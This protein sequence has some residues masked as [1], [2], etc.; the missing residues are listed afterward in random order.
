M[1]CG[2]VGESEAGT[3]RGDNPETSQCSI[4]VQTD[5]KGKEMRKAECEREGIRDALTRLPNQS[6]EPH[7]TVNVT[8]YSI[9]AYAFVDLGFHSGTCAAM[10]RQ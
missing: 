3:H 5:E 8:A 10:L 1:R 7:R 6:Q 9:Q 2:G 4:L